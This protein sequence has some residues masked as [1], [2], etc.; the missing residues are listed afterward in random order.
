VFTARYAL[1]PY[2]KQ[3]RFVFKGLKLQ[4]PARCFFIFLYV[5]MFLLLSSLIS[6]LHVLV[7]FSSFSFSLSLFPSD[8]DTLLFPQMYSWLKP[9][10]YKL[11]KKSR[12]NLKILGAIRVTRSKS[13]TEDPQILGTTVP[14]IVS[15]AIWRPGF[16]CPWLKR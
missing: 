7:A 14:N 2:I 10:V 15:T 12:S 9:W 5:S 1:S 4:A 6:L 8:T 3:I 13:H 11:F 16:V